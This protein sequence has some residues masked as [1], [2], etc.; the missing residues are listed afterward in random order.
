MLYLHPE[1][2][3]CRAFRHVG[4][5]YAAGD[6]DEDGAFYIAQAAAEEAAGI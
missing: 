5:A 3:Q 2:K 4:F 1:S 6:G